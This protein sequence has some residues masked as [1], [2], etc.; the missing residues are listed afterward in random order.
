MIVTT[1]RDEHGKRVR[2]RRWRC[3]P[4]MALYERRPLPSKYTPHQGNREKARRL[5]RMA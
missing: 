3:E 5:S 1:S 2:L 4:R